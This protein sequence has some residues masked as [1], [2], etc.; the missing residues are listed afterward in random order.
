MLQSSFCPPRKCSRPAVA[1]LRWLDWRDKSVGLRAPDCLDVLNFDGEWNAN[2]LPAKIDR[3]GIL[4]DGIEA[5]HQP[6]LIVAGHLW[7]RFD[8]QRVLLCVISEGA[9]LSGIVVEDD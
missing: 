8:A 3:G 6:L 5:I 2:S 9:P 4:G 7:L 1:A